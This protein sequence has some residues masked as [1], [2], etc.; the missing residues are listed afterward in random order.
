[1]FPI[2][3]TGALHVEQIEDECI[4]YDAACHRVHCLSPIAALVWRNCDGQRTAK[5]LSLV[6]LKEGIKQTKRWFG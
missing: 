3:R 6:L 2:A 5:D 4:V 1:M